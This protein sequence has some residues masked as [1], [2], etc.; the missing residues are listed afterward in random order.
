MALFCGVDMF[1]LHGDDDSNWQWSFDC[2]VTL[3]FKLSLSF[4]LLV[5]F[6]LPDYCLF[7]FSFYC[8]KH[9]WPI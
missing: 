3:L 9:M 8:G 2:I 1:I 6:V 5:L 7:S 4:R